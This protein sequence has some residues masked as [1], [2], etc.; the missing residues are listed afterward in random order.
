MYA[1]IS[2]S[3]LARVRWLFAAARFAVPLVTPLGHARACFVWLLDDDRRDD[4]DAP[5]LG[6]ATLILN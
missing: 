1:R 2:R 6:Q 4:P 3:E 5:I